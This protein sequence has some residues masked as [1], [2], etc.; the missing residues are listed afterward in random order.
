MP[1][2]SRF[3]ARVAGHSVGGKL[4]KKIFT[5]ILGALVTLGMLVGVSAPAQAA[6]D[7]QI[8]FSQDSECARSGEYCNWY[9]LEIRVK[10]LFG[11]DGNPYVDTEDEGEFTLYNSTGK[12]VYS[13]S[14]FPRA[15]SSTVYNDDGYFGSA[16]SAMIMLDEG[17]TLPKGQYTL[18]AVIRTA[19]E[20]ENCGWHWNWNYTDVFNP[21]ADPDYSGPEKGS[22]HYLTYSFNWNGKS[23][24]T[25][26]QSFTATEKKSATTIT[27]YTAKKSSSYTASAS[28]TSKQ[29]AKFKHKG[30][31]YKATASVTSKKSHKVTKTATIK[32]NKLKRTATATAKATS[33][34]SAADAKKMAAAKATKDAK[35]A[36]TTN[37][38]AATEKKAVA[39][40]KSLLTKKVTDAAKTKAKQKITAKVK[41]DTQ[42]KAYA[43]ALKSAKKKAAVK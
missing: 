34:H 38:K 22:T 37:A 24:K 28:Y 7:K 16:Y 21:C 29:T 26:R 10:E 20:E 39:K 27:T 42:K 1:S 30:K 18:R 23:L 12:K 4:I 32:A 41:S 25:N 14:I 33:Y 2:Y 40:A 9:D 8:V 11:S 3:N 43:A 36:A 19:D 6:P 35:K 5:L 15:A 17:K 13:D 31:T